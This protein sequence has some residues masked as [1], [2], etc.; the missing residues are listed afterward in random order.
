MLRVEEIRQGLRR[1]KELDPGFGLFGA[2][3]HHYELNPPLPEEDVTEFECKHSIRLPA[4]YRRFL[5]NLGNGGAGPTY[6]LFPLDRHDDGWKFC[7]FE[8]G[9]L[10]G[11]LAQ[12]FTHRDAWNANNE[13]WS[14]EPDLESLTQEEQHQAMETWDRLLETEYWSRSI[15][16]GAIP[17]C[18]L[19]CAR[20][21]WLVVTGAEQGNVWVDD[22]ADN[23]G[24]YPLRSEEGDR[25]DFAQWYMGWMSDSL[26][27]AEKKQ[28][29]S[30][31]ASGV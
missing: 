20:R 7:S 13:L 11:D 14:R 26:L 21:Q 22:R 30:C 25:V 19:G 3:S 2:N 6:G 27:A 16:G 4:D 31:F 24:V 28:P 15:M 5:L 23:R 9:F 12:A 18:H 17:I 29:E 10:V 8:S 1:L